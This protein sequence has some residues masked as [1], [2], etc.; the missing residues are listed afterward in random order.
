MNQP[1]R[2]R[3]ISASVIGLGYVGLPSAVL[4]ARGG[5]EV[6]G[7][8]VNPQ[9]I[10]AVSAGRAP[11]AEPG[12]GEALADVVASGR[13]RA[14]REPGTTEA[15]L[16]MVPTPLETGPPPSADLSFVQAAVRAVAPKLV[17]GAL[18]MLGSTSPIGTT[19]R[20]LEACAALRPDLQITTKDDSEVD[21][22]YAPE[23]V[24]PGRTMVEMRT[25]E[26]LIGGV[27]A[28]AAARG[29]ALLRTFCSSAVHETDD[30][31]AEMVKLAENASRDVQIAF[32]NELAEVA[33]QHGLDPGEV[34]TL[35]N[36]HPRVSILSPGV[37]VGG[38]CI[39]VDPWFLAGAI[40]PPARLMAAARAVNDA[41]PGQVADR[42]LSLL[43][44]GD[45][46]ACLGLAYKPD[47]DDFRMSPA[48]AI[49]SDLSRRLPGRVVASD[50]APL[51]LAASY[52][53]IAG[54]LTMM[55]QAGAI[56]SADLVAILVAHTP[57]R[58]L[59]PRPGAR[60]VD[61]TRGIGSVVTVEIVAGA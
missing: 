17:P 30:R 28:R 50:P 19:R 35:A 29:A 21:F 57:Y 14:A 16:L 49:A 2:L 33:E 12:L 27:T 15:Y 37:G 56:A 41:R 48:L 59:G 32:A 61:L 4:L 5:V 18:V 36:R 22:A 3:P 45:R 58:H 54:R 10:E 7:C 42:I 31:T 43:G 20:V 6:E 24:M 1:E 38:H 60:L 13:L 44:P 40:S 53:E 9:V 23:R 39:P 55:D 46:L 26:R 11:I 25:N 51:A 34:I 47:V 8:D 52:P